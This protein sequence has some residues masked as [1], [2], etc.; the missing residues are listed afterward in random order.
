MV[1]NYNVY[2]PRVPD[3]I[4]NELKQC[5][6]GLEK[7]IAEGNLPV[8]LNIF[9][10]QPDYTSYIITKKLI[11]KTLLNKFPD[12]CPVFNITIH[13]PENPLKIG[14]EATFITSGSAS[15]ETKYWNSVPYVV[16]NSGSYKE[17]WG[18][19]LGDDLFQN[20]TREAAFAAFDQVSGILTEENMTFNDIVRQ[21]NYIGDILRVR[22][23]YQNYQIF[24]EVR[25]E[26]YKRFRNIK[27]YPAATGIG[28][29]FGGVFLDFCA[30]KAGSNL[31][32][33][34]LDNPNQINAYEYGQQVLKGM[35]DLGKK[36]KNPPQFERAL[37]IINSTHKSLLISGT[38][39]IKGQDTIGKA[40]VREQTEVTIENINKL[41][42]IKRLS[43]IF[44]ESN[45]KGKYT[46]LRVY[47]KK[48]EDF[49]EVRKI[50]NDNFPMVPAIFV[51]SDICRN[52]LLT[53]IEA[54][55]LI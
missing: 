1:K 25:S 18:A 9:V 54:E 4:E 24:N 55:F 37:L 21:W 6:A 10:N 48:Q 31:Q 28:M 22:K 3:T 5:L 43:Q 44:G 17:V 20:N 15:I 12:N 16:I 38:A 7:S 14:I 29:K 2:L 35:P 46:L 42:D 49:P 36:L 52:D 8:K 51:E 39:S 33:R 41:A 27:W 50:C 32:I 19:G 45:L 34:G 47:I 53:E 30:I 40:N 26:Y 13:P 23:G 11:T